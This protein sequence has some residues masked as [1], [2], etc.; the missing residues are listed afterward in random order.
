[1]SVEETDRLIA[2]LQTA[3]AFGRTRMDKYRDFRKVFLGDDTGRRVLLDI[4]DIC[5]YGKNPAVRGDPHWTYLQCGTLNAAQRILETIQKEPAD[6]PTQ[7]QT[8]PE[9]EYDR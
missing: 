7:Q 9:T 1:M 2:D 8:K 4:L 6:Q 5:G 3:K